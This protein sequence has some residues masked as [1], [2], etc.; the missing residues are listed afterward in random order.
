ME[1]WGRNV[2][3]SLEKKG[4]LEEQKNAVVC[5]A[6]LLRNRNAEGNPKRTI[7]C[8]KETSRT[9]L[10]SLTCEP[11]RSSRTGIRSNSSLSCASE[12]QLLMGTA[13]C[14]WKMYEVGELSMM[15]VSRRSRPIWDRS[16]RGV[17]GSIVK[18]ST[19]SGN[20]TNL[21]VVAL[22]VVTALSEQAMVDDLVNVQLIQKRITVLQAMTESASWS[23]CIASH[24]KQLPYLGHRGR[25]DDHLIQLADAFHE[26]VDP[27]SFDDV[28]VV[29]LTFD[30]DG[31]GEVGLMENLT[32]VSAIIR[33]SRANTHGTP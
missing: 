23:L 14:G 16:C 29:I 3:S 25:E 18:T 31:D 21:D 8:H 12:N 7:R 9:R 11:A 27:G 4:S 13:C 20:T 17:R 28:D 15:I 22:M 33:A 19:T 26:L 30:L 32:T 1:R 2:Q 6:V 10:T 24:L 5:S